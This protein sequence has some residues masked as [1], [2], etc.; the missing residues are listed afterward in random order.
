[1]EGLEK[2]WKVV[3]ANSPLELVRKMSEKFVYFISGMGIS[4]FAI[5]MIMIMIRVQSD[6]AILRTMFSDADQNSTSA[7]YAYMD[8]TCTNDVYPQFEVQ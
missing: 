4:R 7:S 6:Q 1:M 2:V 5:S 3:F 8:C